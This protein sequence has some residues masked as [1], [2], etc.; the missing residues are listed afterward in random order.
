MT[1]ISYAQNFEDIILWRAL[2][3]IPN[4]FYIDIGAN[5]PETDSVT[6]L[7]YDNGWSGVNIEPLS[8]HWNDLSKQRRN[9]INIQCAIS[10]SEGYLDIWECDVRGWAT[11][12]KTIAESHELA[13]HIG[14]WN[15]TPVKLLKNVLNE[16]GL[17][18]ENNIHFLKID[19][20]GL[21]FNVLN[22]NDWLIYRPWLIVIEATEP[23]SQVQN[24]EGWEYI[25]TDNMYHFVYFDGLNRFYVSNERAELDVY[26]NTPP[27]VF[28]DF[29]KSSEHSAVEKNKKIELY[30]NEINEELQDIK[31][32]LGVN[33]IEVEKLREVAD[34]NFNKLQLYKHELSNIKN[35]KSW[36]ITKPFRFLSKILKGY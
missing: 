32:E 13:G 23:N 16:C 22:S 29:I 25:L 31:K 17:S 28:D 24:F 19:V 6:K 11:I 7:F 35:S 1:I 27:N 34:A 18:S 5:D 8:L 4:G 20:E 30:N 21:E 9:D 2:K 3:N 33:L 12:N 14:I 26:F 15:K 10:D 36:K